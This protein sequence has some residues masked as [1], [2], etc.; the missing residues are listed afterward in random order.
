MSS[1]IR[2]KIL[3]TAAR[4]FAAH[5]YAA[6]SMRRLATETGMT[7]ANLYYHFKD[8]EDLVRST[9]AYAFKD[10]NLSLEEA[11][12]GGNDPESR[13]EL[14]ISW[15]ARN[16]FEDAILA[17]LFIR[18]LLVAD[19]ERMKYLTERIFQDTF[20]TLVGLLQDYLGAQHAVL[21]GLALT[22]TILG[23]FQISG[24]TKHLDEVRPELVDPETI[25]KFLMNEL[26]KKVRGCDTA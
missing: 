17:K 5:G 12:T 4:L 19:S 6:V 24:F 22:S 8:K 20:T 7:Q 21:Y 10:R 11:I 14:A 13:L 15:F 23:F 1:D 2:N 3:E 18:E 9:L 16:L 25:S 26:R